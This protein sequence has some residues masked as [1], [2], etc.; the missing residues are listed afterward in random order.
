MPNSLGEKIVENGSR[1]DDIERGEFF[2][3]AVSFNTTNLI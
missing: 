2:F 3:F 1:R